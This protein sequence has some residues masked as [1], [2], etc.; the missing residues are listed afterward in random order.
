MKLKT[1]K[2]KNKMNI[3]IGQNNLKRK[4]DTI[5]PTAQDMPAAKKHNEP[6]LGFLFGDRGV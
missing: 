2:R 4:I 6:L 1:L 5:L 3:T